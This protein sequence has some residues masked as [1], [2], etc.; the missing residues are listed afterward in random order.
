MVVESTSVRTTVVPTGA[1]VGPATLPMV[2]ERSEHVLSPPPSP[3]PPRTVSRLNQNYP[4]FREL[5]ESKPRAL[6]V[7]SVEVEDEVETVDVP[8]VL[9]PSGPRRPVSRDPGPSSRQTRGTR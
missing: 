7:T 9:S 3:E 4:S 2:V 8:S 6:S 5:V 1:R